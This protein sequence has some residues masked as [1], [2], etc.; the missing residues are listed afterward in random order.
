MSRQRHFDS[1][2]TTVEEFVALFDLEGV[3]NTHSVMGEERFQGAI[4]D[5]INNIMEEANGNK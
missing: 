3:P 4:Y 2:K 5:K 1:F